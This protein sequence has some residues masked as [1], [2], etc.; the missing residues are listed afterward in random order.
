MFGEWLRK[1]PSRMELTL[2]FPLLIKH[3]LLIFL[4]R[5]V[6]KA[7]LIGLF[8][9]FLTHRLILSFSLSFIIA[10][11]VEMLTLEKW[12]QK[13]ILPRHLNNLKKVRAMVDVSPEL[14]VKNIKRSA[15]LSAW[16]IA[17][18]FYLV[19]PSWGWE[20]IFR[21]LYSLMVKSPSPAYQELLIGFRHQSFKADQELW[22]IS[23]SKDL[24]EKERLLND[25]L[26]NYGSRVSDLDLSLPTLR[27][28]SGAVKKLVDL[29]QTSLS[30][31][32]RLLT[33]EERRKTA[34]KQIETRLKVPKSFFRWLLEVV[35]RNVAL[36]EDRRFYEFVMD[37]DLRQMIIK[38]GQNLNINSQVVFNKSWGELK[39]CCQK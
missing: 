28:Q 38:L 1:V 10:L 29:Y 30:P 23:Q 39:K 16:G 14:L 11:T 8:L 7:F 21:F 20:I 25:Y 36:R 6:L 33:A 18:I 22:R 34:L 26:E 17:N 27:E 5:F 24:S 9:W 37:Y 15:D 3:F 12:Y 19:L 31:R 13:K 4:K 32:I 35:R 2:R